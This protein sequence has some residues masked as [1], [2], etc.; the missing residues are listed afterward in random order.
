MTGGTISRTRVF[1][2][3]KTGKLKAKKA[4]K[5]TIITVDEAKRYIDA[6]PDRLPDTAA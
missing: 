5:R 1:D 6:L 2:D 3:I 4:G